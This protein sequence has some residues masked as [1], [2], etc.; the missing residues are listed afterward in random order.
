MRCSI[1]DHEFHYV[2]E[3]KTHVRCSECGLE[4]HRGPF[5]PDPR[6]AVPVEGER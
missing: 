4:M 5:D 6:A 2:D 3:S 1:E